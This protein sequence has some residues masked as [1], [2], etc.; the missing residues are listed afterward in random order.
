LARFFAVVVPSFDSADPL[1]TV[2]FLMSA[3]SPFPNAFLAMP[4]KTRPYGGQR[5]K[6][7]S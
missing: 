3:P 7:I 2:G 4:G 6:L 1:V 5:A